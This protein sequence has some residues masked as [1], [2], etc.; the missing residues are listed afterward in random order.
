MSVQTVARTRSGSSTRATAREELPCTMSSTRPR[1]RYHA[2]DRLPGSSTS[3]AFGRCSAEPAP[4]RTCHQDRACGGSRAREVN[5]Q[6]GCLET[7][8]SRETWPRARASSRG[9]SRPLHPPKKA[10]IRGHRRRSGRRS[11]SSSHRPQKATA[12][13]CPPRSAPRGRRPRVV[14]R[15]RRARHAAGADERL[16]AIRVGGGEQ[17][18]HRTPSDIPTS[19][20]RSD[21]AAIP[22]P[23][24]QRRPSA[25]L[26]SVLRRPGPK[27][28]AASSYMITRANETE[29]LEESR[30][31]ALL[32]QQPRRG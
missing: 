6:N 5:R 17:D 25:A 1:R 27:A 10:R 26:A 29:P 2:R 22:S 12:T 4:F 31:R 21:P 7:S 14:L 13:R 20:A 9:R 28:R 15:V 18:R 30:R 23:R 24:A 3:V 19:A 11:R 8:R 32:P 16:G